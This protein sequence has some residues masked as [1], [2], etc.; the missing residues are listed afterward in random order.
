M[1][2]HL[3]KTFLFGLLYFT[4]TQ[5]QILPNSDRS[6]QQIGP[7]S[8]LPQEHVT[9]ISQDSLGFMW[10]GTANG[11][12]RFDGETMKVYFADPSDSSALSSSQIQSLFT[13][14]NG[15][16]WIG[17]G[18]LH[19]YNPAQDTFV[20]YSFSDLPD[21]GKSLRFP[22]TMAEDSAGNLWIGTFGAGLFKLH[23][24]SGSIEK[25][26]LGVYNKES[27]SIGR[28]IYSLQIDNADTVWIASSGNQ[29]T[30][31]DL[32]TNSQQ[33]FFLTSN[34][35]VQYL[36]K[37]KQGIKWLSAS[38]TLLQRF[39][40][41]RNSNARL[42]QIFS[43]ESS[44][45]P[46]A[47]LREEDGLLWLGTSESG[48]LTHNPLSGKKQWHRS[49][50]INPNSIPGNRIED[51]FRDRDGNIWIATMNGLAFQS[52]WQKPFRHYKY[53]PEDPHSIS[54]GL[55]TGVHEAS[56]GKV[57][58]STLYKGI[59]FFDIHENSFTRLFEEQRGFW[60]LG[61]TADSYNNVW[62]AGNPAT[63]LI[64]YRISDGDLKQFEHQAEDKSS[65][66]GNAISKILEDSKRRIW[67]A[68]NGGG[69]NLY[70]KQTETFRRFYHDKQNE[71][72][73]GSNQITALVEQAD[74][75]L[76]I[77]TD[78]GLNSLDLTH[79]TIK[80]Y[81]PDEESGSR[82]NII[83]D[84]ALQSGNGNILT[85]TPVGVMR[86]DM[87]DQNYRPLSAELNQSAYGIL[88]DAD[89]NL[90]VQQYTSLARFDSQ[91][92]EVRIYDRDDD[93]IQS[94]AFE[95]GWRQALQRLSNGEMIFGGVKGITRFHPSEVRDNLSP[96]PVHITGF[97]LFYEPVTLR[98]NPTR[99]KDRKK[100]ILQSSVITTQNMTLSHFQNT[101]SF[102][103]SALDYSRR[104]A[105]Q[106][107]YMLEGFH[108]GWIYSGNENTA[109][110][111]NLSPGEYVF[112]V[113]GS[114]SDGVWNEL[115]DSMKI[116]ILTPWWKTG[117]AY[118]LWLLLGLAAAYLLWR[119][120][121][122][123]LIL[124]NRLAMQSFEAEK[125]K[126]LDSLKSRFFANISHEFRTPLTLILGPIDSL[127]SN[128]EDSASREQLSIMKRNAF[129]LQ[130]LINQLLDLSRIESQKMTLQIQPGDL[131]RFLSGLIMSF[132]SFAEQKKIQLIVD[133]P[134]SVEKEC[135]FDPDKLEKIISNLLSNAFKFTPE[136]GTITVRGAF[137]QKS[138]NNTVFQLVVSDSGIGI[139]P[140][141]LEV[142]F[143][144]FQQVDSS[145]KRA[146]EGSGIGLALVKEMVELHGGHI[147][148][149][150]APGDGATFRVNLPVS[151]EAFPEDAIVASPAATEPLHLQQD[152]NLLKPANEPIAQTI[153]DKSSMPL[154][155]LV[156]DHLDV[157]TFIRRQ[158]E[159]DYRLIE[160]SNGL[161]ALEKSFNAVPDLII[162]DV[163]MPEMDGYELCEKLKTDERTSH[164]PVIL[165]TARAGEEDKLTGLETGA[166]DYLTKPFNSQELLTRVRNLIAS[167][168]KL[169][170]HFLQDWLKRGEQLP[171]S[172]TEAE[173]LKKLR[174]TLD[175]HLTDE[176]LG[177]DKLANLLGLGKR[178]L[179]RKISALTNE[180]A[181][182]LIRIAR[183]EKAK[184][185]LENN[186]GSVSEV[187]YDVGFSHLSYFARCFRERFG[188]SPSDV[189]K[190]V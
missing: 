144:R 81:S 28:I 22:N 124:N 12:C 49:H 137:E 107:A 169:R 177:V 151:R 173:F 116:L 146:Y 3:L 142:I 179:Q 181:S 5:A 23:A 148:V 85:A 24:N 14:S 99:G 36:F 94:G 139:A 160:A 91:S 131:V 26:D 15:N 164:I 84:L 174:S 180:T 122:Q 4:T 156:D 162:S 163:M 58:I 63:G 98:N 118:T 183:L 20:R 138:S 132:A 47:I 117:W 96:P 157:R 184:H 51:I 10:F 168:E 83:H 73:L 56:D 66:G 119:T 13:D 60:A 79:F 182:S 176:H 67:I 27:S 78:K 189:R 70:D 37:D 186:A 115:G 7:E 143:E 120:L 21:K 108:G 112:R 187:A 145:S 17:A 34:G 101:F 30:S 16:L 154:I 166:D 32:K 121:T 45:S 110:F 129:R 149:K 125:L 89:G 52:N 105:I 188:V 153:T 80:R 61:I 54:D 77:G 178:Q 171:V 93:W 100:R 1:V 35:D 72:S 53:S 82:K 39:E 95:S 126:E 31:I 9:T 134:T 152:V 165:L 40:W 18:G 113:K 175:A 43:G 103:F 140:E 86:Y 136:L 71:R 57:W 62:I 44:M 50:S 128:Q 33:H 6:F 150:S 130:Q 8:G 114:N 133:I 19:R 158:L 69:L 48:I 167:R 135:Y 147:S 25:I 68:T 106:Y 159:A 97:R 102:D 87:A 41:D 74:S 65:L 190:K 172:S 92:R 2:R 11:L 185:L 64:R 170:E 29:I 38:G 127:I 104:D 75:L 109:T 90:W 59:A 42:T 161:N 46:T 111:T 123:R 88:E 141:E 76:W 155:L 55:V